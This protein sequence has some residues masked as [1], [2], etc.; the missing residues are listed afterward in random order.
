MG[1]AF[2]TYLKSSFLAVLLALYP[3][4]QTMAQKATSVKG[5][6]AAEAK[7]E[8]VQAV[9]VTSPVLVPARAET[10]TRQPSKVPDAPENAAIAPANAAATGSPGNGFEIHGTAKGIA[11]STW[12]LI[13]R[14]DNT[15]VHEPIDSAMVINEKFELTGTIEEPALLTVLRTKNFSDYRFLWLENKQLIFNGEKG[16]FKEAKVSGSET[17]L[18]NMELEARIA[19]I[20]NSL[21]SLQAV[22]QNTNMAEADSAGLI[23][24]MQELEER[25]KQQYISFVRENP[26]SVVSA[27]IL[28]TYKTTWGKETTE[29]LFAGLSGANRNTNYGATVNNFLLLNKSPKVGEKFADFSQPTLDGKQV[30]LSDYRGKVVLLEFWASNCGPCRVENPNL[31]KTYKNYKSKGFDVLGVSLDVNRDHWKKAVEKDGLTWV[32]V[33]E[34]N[35]SKNTAALIY[36]ISAIPDNFLID[37]DGTIIGR[38]MRG[39]KLNERLAELLKE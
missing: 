37:R 9:K 3:V 5:I 19:P 10:V 27:Y 33:S 31:V 15:S 26:V 30:K 39:E 34:L 13:E 23:R 4:T 36:G 16:K 17:E 11:D 38:N 12:I 2:K 24:Q 29:D 1:K 32:N 14:A 22:I 21:D 20:R 25:A 35:G 8:T 28:D 18:K 6:E 7:A